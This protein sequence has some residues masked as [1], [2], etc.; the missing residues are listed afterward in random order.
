MNYRQHL[1]ASLLGVDLPSEH[2]LKA[3]DLDDVHQ[4]H[5]QTIQNI[6]KKYWNDT[7]EF[8]SQFLD[9]H[10]YIP[11]EEQRVQNLIAMSDDVFLTYL[12]RVINKH[13]FKLLA[14]ADLFGWDVSY[15]TCVL[16]ELI[17]RFPEVSMETHFH[18]LKQ[19]WITSSKVITIQKDGHYYWNNERFIYLHDTLNIPAFHPK[20]N[21]R[22]ELVTALL[23]DKV[24]PHST[25]NIQCCG[26][27]VLSNEYN[28][29]HILN[30]LVK[31]AEQYP[32]QLSYQRPHLL[33]S[34]L[35]TQV[36]LNDPV[37]SRLAI[38]GVHQYFNYPH[39]NVTWVL[40]S[41]ADNIV[42]LYYQTEDQTKYN[43][44]VKMHYIPKQESCLYQLLVA[45]LNSASDANDSVLD[46][47]H[48]LGKTDDVAD[49][50]FHLIHTHFAPKQS[51]E[52]FRMALSTM[53]DGV[54]CTRSYR[55]YQQKTLSYDEVLLTF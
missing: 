4:K 38:E 13:F 37:L 35:L 41:I 2:L 51:P 8:Y 54:Q 18:R 33:L 21:L 26:W 47:M 25:L 6:K 3:K 50:T 30:T 46:K 9:L 45:L 42:F 52:E 12:P 55:K 23:H 32:L 14:E 16:V 40:S 48:F 43:I 10:N 29:H 39:Q 11:Q 17:R 7:S 20:G 15:N 31:T 5:Y 49:Y 1:Y 36:D 19:Q 28:I 24:P 27:Q 34:H 22:T 53:I 44:E